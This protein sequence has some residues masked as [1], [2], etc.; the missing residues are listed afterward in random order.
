MEP[1]FL[2]EPETRGEPSHS[3]LNPWDLETLRA[4]KDEINIGFIAN[5]VLM[6]PEFSPNDPGTPPERT[7][8]PGELDRKVEKAEE[9]EKRELVQK[10][11]FN[12]RAQDG[13]VERE[14]SGE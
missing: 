10:G 13:G 9:K 5:E 4:V 2:P 7:E 8:G 14:L 12:K 6:D 11:A 1:E 3:P